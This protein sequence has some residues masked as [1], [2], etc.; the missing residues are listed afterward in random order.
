MIKKGILFSL[1]VKGVDVSD[2]RIVDLSE[3]ISDL[4]LGGLVINNEDQGV[5]VFNLLHGLFS[6]QGMLND[7]VFI[8]T[9]LDGE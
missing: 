3:S 1:R 7:G 4:G 9:R 5:F 6:I 8:E 2:L